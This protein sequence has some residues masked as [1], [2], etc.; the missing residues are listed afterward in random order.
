MEAEAAVAVH[1]PTFKSAMFSIL[2]YVKILAR[3]FLMGTLM[4][5]AF[6][7]FME[8]FFWFLRNKPWKRSQ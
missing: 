7:P 8:L 1:Q 4:G 3:K 2:T 5:F 6:T